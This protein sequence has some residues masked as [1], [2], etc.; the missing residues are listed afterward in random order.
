MISEEL[1]RKLETLPTQPGVYLMK[2]KAGDVV[3]VGKAVS[4]RARVNQYFQERTGDNRAFIPFLEDLLGDV[5]VMITPSEKDSVLLEN[6]L[7][8]RF[9][10]RFNVKL[11]DDKNFISL[12]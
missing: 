12:P 3:Y 9:R 2:D 8:K 4:L 10:P 5:E 11:R 6:E 7:I 1:Q